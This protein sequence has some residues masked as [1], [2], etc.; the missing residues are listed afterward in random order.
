MAPD[1]RHGDNPDAANAQ[2]GD[3]DA[4]ASEGGPDSGKPDDG[5]A[6]RGSGSGSGSGEVPWDRVDDFLRGRRQE[7][8]GDQWNFYGSVNARDFNVGR[9]GPR[10]SSATSTYDVPPDALDRVRAVYLPPTCDAAAW[11]LLSSQHLV[12]LSASD[13][14]GRICAALSLLDRSTGT[15]GDDRIKV[16]RIASAD[17]HALTAL[18][19]E[20]HDRTI[21]VLEA[22]GVGDLGQLVLESLSHSLRSL[23][24]YLV[25]SLD[26]SISIPPR[27]GQEFVVPWHVDLPNEKLL[28][29]HLNW[30]LRGKTVVHEPRQVVQSDHVRRL[31]DAVM[32]PRELSELAY[33]LADV[34]VNHGSLEELLDQALDRFQLQV[35]KEVADWFDQSTRR[36][37][38]ALMIALATLDGATSALVV[39]AARRLGVLLP[40]HDSGE[41]PLLPLS[42]RLEHV[43]ARSTLRTVQTEF[44]PVQQEVLGARSSKWSRSVL[45]HA[46]TEQDAIHEQL[47]AFWREISVHHELECR[48]CLVTALA[49]ICEFGFPTVLRELLS[50]W[51]QEEDH[52]VRLIVSA[53]LGLAGSG[54]SESAAQVRRLLRHWSS[55]GSNPML[56][57]TAALAYGWVGTDQPTV[58]LQGLTAMVDSA[59]GYLMQVICHSLVMMF[60]GRPDQE[61]LRVPIRVVVLDL[62]LEWSAERPPLRTEALLAFVEIARRRDSTEEAGT[63]AGWPVLLKLLD[64]SEDGYQ[65]AMTLWLRCLD[66]AP[67]RASALAELMEWVTLAADET[68]FHAVEGF[69]GALA[70][71]PPQ[72]N[73]DRLRYQLQ[74]LARQGGAGADPARRLL[75]LVK[76]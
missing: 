22:G 69:L 7:P 53:V 4:A 32:L 73:H 74:R 38:Y 47:L 39:A 62:L 72:H 50:P 46:W 60:E 12:I 18:E 75:T 56:R 70:A 49:T 59:N 26:A 54:E 14:A 11:R 52:G 27:M 71:A 20:R 13:G 30:Y 65:V 10:G 19:S 5:D 6:Q 31:L 43:R 23:D 44:G 2:A 41:E 33:V 51:A 15:D 45:R 42:R 40:P 17:V 25:V 58:A 55:L 37:E 36:D 34:V 28:W 57:W 29:S 1:D 24:A 8:R 35:D 63:Q 21:A 9:K 67:A 3:H 66:H 68:L 48:W 64:E 61:D 76:E 16:L